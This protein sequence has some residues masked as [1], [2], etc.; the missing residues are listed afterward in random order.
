MSKKENKQ[1]KNVSKDM[2]NNQTMQRA[3][4]QSEKN[5]TQTDASGNDLKN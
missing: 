4:N 3:Q 1:N 5:N 2:K